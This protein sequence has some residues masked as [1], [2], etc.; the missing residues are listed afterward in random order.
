MR[1]AG[2]GEEPE[3]Y[4]FI[5][6][7]AKFYDAWRKP[8]VARGVFPKRTLPQLAARVQYLVTSH[9]LRPLQYHGLALLSSLFSNGGSPEES[10]K[11]EP[12]ATSIKSFISQYLKRPC[13]RVESPI[14]VAEA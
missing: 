8:G 11:F 1:L 2:L 12:E 9:L 10:F 3:S 4:H 6:L 7:P 14:T 13:P 5:E